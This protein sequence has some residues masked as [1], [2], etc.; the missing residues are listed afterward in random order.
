M[1][2]L[3]IQEAQYILGILEYAGPSWYDSR[4]KAIKILRPKLSVALHPYPELHPDHPKNNEPT[5][6]GWPLYSGLPNGDTN[7]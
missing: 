2:T 6:D 3:T 5:I 7:D 4:T 1:I